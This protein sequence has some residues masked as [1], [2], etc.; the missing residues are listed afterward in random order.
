MWRTFRSA[1]GLLA[2]LLQPGRP[3]HEKK[4]RSEN[5][6][7]K[8]KKGRRGTCP[9]IYCR[10]GITDGWPKMRSVPSLTAM[11]SGT[12]PVGASLG[13]MKETS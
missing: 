4:G 10:I 11:A 12:S 5:L 8:E 13:T 1:A 7:C 6:P 2:G 3:S 9:G